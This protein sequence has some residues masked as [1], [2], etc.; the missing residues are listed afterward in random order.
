MHA[1]VMTEP[2]KGPDRTEDRE[3]PEPHPSA[4]QVS[5]DVGYAG[6]NF[7]DVMARR[8]DPSYATSWPYVPGLEVAGTIR[9]TGS[10]V[11][12]LFTG[13]RVAAFTRGGGLAEVALADAALVVPL[14][15][16]VPL[17][18]AAECPGPTGGRAVPRRSH[19]P[20]SN[21][22]PRPW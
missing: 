7:I 19:W 18:A 3:L 16:E 22:R 2:S 20:G 12:G 5:I 17:P 9:E 4:G 10:G 15:D 6:I 8:G 14:P 11:T 21:T 1:L 13:Q